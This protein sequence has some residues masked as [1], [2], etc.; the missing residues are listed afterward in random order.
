MG[1]VVAN[2]AL[3]RIRTFAELAAAN[4]A[5]VFLLLKSAGLEAD[6]AIRDHDTVSAMLAAA[7]DESDATDYVR[8]SITSATVTVDD[9]NE[10]TDI[11]V[12]DQTWTG[13]G[14]ATNNTL[15][16]LVAAYDAD[17]TSGDDTNLTPI[18]YHD[19]VV[20]TDD[21]DVTAQVAAAGLLRAQG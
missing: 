10:R 2:Q 17:T 15:G 16:K 9:T 20:T 21:S 4:D 14:G 6:S 11:D 18:S 1:N 12:A 3:G 8:K 5:I 19:F 13:L 7:N